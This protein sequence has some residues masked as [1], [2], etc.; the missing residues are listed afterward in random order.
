MWYQLSPFPSSNAAIAM[1]HHPCNI[2]QSVATPCYS[3]S[4]WYV[5]IQIDTISKRWRSRKAFNTYLPR[6]VP[7]QILT[8]SRFK[9]ILLINNGIDWKDHNSSSF[10]AENFTRTAR[11]LQGQ[12]GP[13]GSKVFNTIIQMEADHLRENPQTPQQQETLQA[14][15]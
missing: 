7:K 13:T 15:T 8:L 5:L 10:W 11:S 9:L 4:P 14:I 2:N 1:Q 12:G 3:A 6:S